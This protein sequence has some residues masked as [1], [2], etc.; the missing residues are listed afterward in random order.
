[1]IKHKSSWQYYTILPKYVLSELPRA[2]ASRLPASATDSIPLTGYGGLISTGLTSLRP[3]G[4]II[5]F[6]K[7][8]YKHNT[9]HNHAKA[10]VLSCFVISNQLQLAF[11]LL[12][13]LSYFVLFPAFST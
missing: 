12:L 1:M 10:V 6:I 13:F 8:L 2:K 9:I 4:T 3:V 5:G 7:K 11:D